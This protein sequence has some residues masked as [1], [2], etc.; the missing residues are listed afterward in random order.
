MRQRDPGACGT[1]DCCHEREGQLHSWKAPP[2]GT[3]HPVDRGAR[4]FQLTTE[5]AHAGPGRWPGP[6][7]RAR[8]RLTTP[9]DSQ[10]SLNETPE[11]SRHRSEGGI[12]ARTWVEWTHRHG[13]EQK[14]SRRRERDR[15]IGDARDARAAPPTTGRA[16]STAASGWVPSD[17]AGFAAT[18]IIGSR[19][20]EPRLRHRGTRPRPARL[21]SLSSSGPRAAGERLGDHAIT[22][23]TGDPGLALRGKG[24]AGAGPVGV[25][26]VAD[27]LAGCELRA[28]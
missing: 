5:R 27:A 20:R 4:H 15:R 21:L 13:F 11:R 17:N 26:D 24:Q 9:S 23:A 22:R 12:R 10:A 16:Q 28:S 6:L 8:C 19:L 7:L 18:T 1:V 14:H 2:G 3:H 25:L